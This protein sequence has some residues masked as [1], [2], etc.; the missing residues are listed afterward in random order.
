MPL[1]DIRDAA[2]ATSA[3]YFSR[4]HLSGHAVSAIVD[5]H[6]CEP[7]RRRASVSVIAPRCAVADALTKIVLL[8]EQRAT[9]VLRQCAAS[10]VVITASGRVRTVGSHAA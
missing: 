10:A 1:A 6:R 5:P 9:S 4:R 3:T 2:V 8:D 7:C